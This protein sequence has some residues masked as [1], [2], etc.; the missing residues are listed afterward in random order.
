MWFLVRHKWV[1]LPPRES[2]LHSVE[3]R[4]GDSACVQFELGRSPPG[5]SL[6]GAGSAMVVTGPS[7]PW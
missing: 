3:G 7:A 6:S 5:G 1:L 4:E 2:A